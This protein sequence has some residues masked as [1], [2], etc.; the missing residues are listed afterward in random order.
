[1]INHPFILTL[2]RIQS[3]L[4][5]TILA[6]GLTTPELWLN[7]QRNYDLWQAGSRIKVAHIRS[8]RTK[9][10]RVKAN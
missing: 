2:L 3:V 10:K 8:L 7:M 5:T 1:M 9:E 4:L 6:I